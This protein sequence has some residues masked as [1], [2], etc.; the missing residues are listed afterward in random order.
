[1]SIFNEFN[2]F[3]VS[4]VHLVQE[5]NDL[6]HANLVSKQNVLASLWHRAVVAE[7]TRIAPSI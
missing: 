4:K 5:D 6:W 3:R 1:M 7:T 2:E